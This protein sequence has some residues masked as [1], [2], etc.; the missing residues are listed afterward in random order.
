MVSQWA[1]HRGVSHRRIAEQGT[2]SCV[3][4]YR[5]GEREGGREGAQAK[6]VGKPGTV[7]PCERASERVIQRFSVSAYQ[8][9]WRTGSSGTSRRFWSVLNGIVVGYLH[10]ALRAAP[11][12]VFVTQGNP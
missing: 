8:L 5:M 12:R 11:P 7:Y 9:A 3:R 4:M 6:R 10:F 2:T 1:Y